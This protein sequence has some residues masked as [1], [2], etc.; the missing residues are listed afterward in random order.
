MG[1]SLRLKQGTVGNPLLFT[2]LPKLMF[3]SMTDMAS[4]SAGALRALAMELKNIESQPL[5]G[6]TISASDDNLF[7]WTVGIYG[8]PN[9]LYQ[10]G[11]FKAVIRFP[12]N[13][14][15]SP[16]S[17]KFL[18]KVWHPN[19][20]ENGDLCISILHPPVDD[21]HSGELPCERWNP[22][23]SV[24]TILLSV[25]SLLNEP[26][27]S[28]PANVDASVMYRKWKDGTDMSYADII[29][30][31]VEQSKEEARKDGVT[32]PET[33][34]EY[35]IKFH[36]QSCED[37]T[38][39]L[40]DLGLCR[41][42]FSFLNCKATTT[43][44][45]TITG[46]T[47][48]MTRMIM[49]RKTKIA[50]KAK[51]NT[52]L[53]TTRLSI[54]IMSRRQNPSEFLKQ[55][56]GKPVVVKLNSGVDYRGILACLDGFMN[57]ALEQTEE[58]NNGQ[59]QNKYGD[60][61]IRGNNVLYISTLKRTSHTRRNLKSTC[62]CRKRSSGPAGRTRA[63]DRGLSSPLLKVRPLRIA[64]GLG[65]ISLPAGAF[66]NGAGSE[67]AT[68][69]MTVAVRYPTGK[70]ARDA[71][72]EREL[73]TCC[74]CKAPLEAIPLHTDDSTGDQHFFWACKNMKKKRCYFPMG[75]PNKVFWLRRTAEERRASFFPRPSVRQLPQEFRHFYPTVFAD[76]ASRNPSTSRCVGNVSSTA[77]ESLSCTTSSHSPSASSSSISSEN[78]V[79]E[80]LLNMSHDAN[81]TGASIWGTATNESQGTGTT[82]SRR[83]KTLNSDVNDGSSGSAGRSSLST[84]A[85]SEVSDGAIADVICD[86]LHEMGVDV[87]MEDEELIRQ[88]SNAVKRL[89]KNASANYFRRLTRAQYRA[90]VEHLFNL[91]VTPIKRRLNVISVNLTRAVAVMRS[92]CDVD[93]MLD[94][95][96]GGS[97]ASEPPAKRIRSA[98]AKAELRKRVETLLE[99][100]A[101]ERCNS[102]ENSVPT[103]EATSAEGA[104]AEGDVAEA[105]PDGAREWYDSEDGPTTS[106]EVEPSNS[107]VPSSAEEERLNAIIQSK[108]RSHVANSA[109]RRHAHRSRKQYQ[110]NSELTQ[111][112]QQITQQEKERQPQIQPSP[113]PLNVDVTTPEHVFDHDDGPLSFDSPYAEDSFAED[114]SLGFNH[115][116]HAQSQPQV[117]ASDTPLISEGDH[118]AQTFIPSS[119]QTSTS[120]SL[121]L[122]LFDGYEFLC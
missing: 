22:T 82:S 93:T 20:Y 67:I 86:Q 9:T 40:L 68:P 81:A 72:I 14:P 101:E 92:E 58:Y 61:F 41:L 98:E 1:S 79:V 115:E 65:W 25:I 63:I 73:L 76:D 43:M 59:L 54:K 42:F 103:A 84:Y 119:L 89:K 11:Y 48:V 122:N 94:A 110:L 106:A 69:V 88:M 30:R 120:D 112:T 97:L 24:R 15:Y 7:V 46:M 13:Y 52:F 37:Q 74:Y 116:D 83:S 47:K 16:P 28:S 111:Q 60:A 23:Q 5:E 26:N 117:S 55:I 90:S 33:L 108:I 62:L 113:M 21:P 104:P 77:S 39:D 121:E 85:P 29:K 100:L 56:I 75:M 70:A 19:V 31:Q 64:V 49:R 114:S 17:M 96:G 32:V 3:Q 6:F 109:A 91:D 4:T 45:C 95:M 34:E 12:P 8:P 36:P 50:D 10:G 57:I 66:E 105:E 27:T 53:V 87:M 38:M 107:A 80:H 102:N 18:T 35:C 78:A 99:K 51:T 2:A 71:Q 118:S 44:T